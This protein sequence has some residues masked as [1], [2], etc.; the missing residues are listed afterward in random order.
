MSF[1]S[2]PLLLATSLAAAGLLVASDAFAH[3]TMTTPISRV[4]AC[5]QGNPEN[6]TNPAC[7]AA[8]AVGG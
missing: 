8:K 2:T 3:G 1:R 7:A 4:Y 6:P 5:F